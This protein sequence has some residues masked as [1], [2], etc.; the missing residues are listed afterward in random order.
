MPDRPDGSSPA[1][2]TT[3]R[4]Y[5]PSR[6]PCLPAAET[7][8]DRETG[9]TAQEQRRPVRSTRRSKGR[10]SADE[11]GTDNVRA[12]AN[13]AIAAMAPGKLKRSERIPAQEKAKQ[14]S[15]SASPQS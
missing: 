15:T 12:S 8:I 7:D 11:A 4:R 13:L 9:R 3:P 6:R 10:S 5:R 1:T 14:R 2:T